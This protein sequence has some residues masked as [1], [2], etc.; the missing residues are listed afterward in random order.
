MSNIENTLRH[1]DIDIPILMKKNHID[2]NY[3]KKQR[4]KYTTKRNIN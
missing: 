4:R 3:S 2:N 1:S